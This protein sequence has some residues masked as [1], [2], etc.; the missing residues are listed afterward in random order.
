MRKDWN[1]L[2]AIAQKLEAAVKEMRKK[3]VQYVYC[4]KEDCEHAKECLHKLF[5]E[6]PKASYQVITVYNPYLQQQEE[7]ECPHLKV[8]G[9]TMK[10]AVGFTAQVG[11]MNPEILKQFQKEC[12]KE[13]CKSVYYDMRAGKRLLSPG[14]QEY[15]RGCAAKVGWDFP[16]NGF[17]KMYTVPSW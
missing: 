1:K 12:M 15:I 9:E 2:K 3:P 17:D 8:A 14:D 13:Y 4:L 10:M 11:R 16:E 5:F 6:V 7:G